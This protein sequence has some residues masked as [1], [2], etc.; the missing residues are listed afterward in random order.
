MYRPSSKLIIALCGFILGLN[1]L[2]IWLI[3]SRLPSAQVLASRMDVPS[4]ILSTIEPIPQKVEKCEPVVD[5]AGIEEQRAVIAR[6]EAEVARLKIAP[7]DDGA[8]WQAKAE[9]LERDLTTLQR[10]A[11]RA[12]TMSG[13]DWQQGKLLLAHALVKEKTR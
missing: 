11:E 10:V 8:A 12:I 13:T 7:A 1:V 2:V 3:D 6:L 5:N 9:Q 4:G